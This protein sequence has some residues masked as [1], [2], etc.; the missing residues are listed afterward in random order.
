MLYSKHLDIFVQFMANSNSFFMSGMFTLSSKSCFLDCR[1]I[2]AR[3]RLLYPPLKCT[4]IFHI[5]DSTKINRPGYNIRMYW[6]NFWQPTVHVQQNMF[7]KTLIKWVVHTFTNLLAPFVPK[8][9]NY[10]RHSKS[11]NIRK[12][13]QIADIFLRWQLFVDF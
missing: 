10:L 7:E 2:W 11:L 13:C 8:L 4:C 3:C 5:T 6:T 1:F 9:F 12:N